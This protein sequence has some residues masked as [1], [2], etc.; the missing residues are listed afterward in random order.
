MLVA[1][2]AVSASGCDLIYRMLDKEGAQEKQIIGKILPYEPNTKVLEAQTLLKIYGYSIGNPD[3][4]LG[5][6]TRD[7]IEKFQKDTGLKP[8]RFL[9]EATW[10]QLH[11]FEDAGLVESGQLNI[12]HIQML[13]KIAG[14]DP[15]SADGSVGP[16]TQKAIKDFQRQHQLPP[17]GR[18]G[19]RTLGAL[20]EYL[21]DAPQ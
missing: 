19:Y 7:M 13:L 4:V 16:K 12:K 11:V 1:I 21:P 15:G 18:I 17:D 6:R 8:S 5:G 9:D 14:F 20:A 10:L 2:A 3:G